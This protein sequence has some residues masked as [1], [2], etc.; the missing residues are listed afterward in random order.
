MINNFVR[1]SQQLSLFAQ[2]AL[3][4]RR[5]L[6]K[7]VDD[8]G[9]VL[10]QVYGKAENFDITVFM[11]ALE[12][13][14]TYATYAM[15]LLYFIPQESLPNPLA[16]HDD[17]TKPLL[18]FLPTD[19]HYRQLCKLIH[20]DRQSAYAKYSALAN[21]AW[22]LWRETLNDPQIKDAPA[23]PNA[24]YN[25]TGFEQY[26][27]QGDVFRRFA[28]IHR[29]YSAAWCSIGNLLTPTKLT[30]AALQQ[31]LLSTTA[32]RELLNAS[33]DDTETGMENLESGIEEIIAQGK[34]FSSSL[35]G[36]RRNG[37]R[38]DLDGDSEESPSEEDE[39][40]DEEP[41][42]EQLDEE[43]E[44]MLASR[45]LVEAWDRDVGRKR[46]RFEDSL[47]PALHRPLR[48]SRRRVQ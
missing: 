22:E 28:S 1:T 37:R 19:T 45:M 32:S 34:L 38:K 8:Y 13:P 47:D 43:V 21:A 3:Q 6:R 11:Y 14:V 5:D 27:A 12:S 46:S 29:D 40:E 33:L 41:E 17:P 2:T 26:C 15:L 31:S 42:V 30:P 16:A 4:Q 18:D 44:A 23:P 25:A 20:P 9:K 48:T 36:H 10:E 7:K 35:S 24:T 39:E